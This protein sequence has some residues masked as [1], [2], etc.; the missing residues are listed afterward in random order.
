MSLVK[1]ELLSP[2]GSYEGFLAAIGA[3]ADAVYCG[4]SLFGARAYAKNF[5]KEELLKAIRIAHIH[6]R[7]LYLTVNT[8]FKNAELE[9]DLYEYLAPF[10]QEGLDAVLVQ[11]MGALSFIREKFPGLPIHASTQ[12]TVTGPL[13]G[14]F[15]KEQGVSRIVAARELSL[16]ELAVLHEETSLEI[17]AFIHGAM[18][19]AYSGQCLMSSLIGGRSGNRGRCAQPC[20][21]PYT[22]CQG[23]DLFGETPVRESRRKEVSERTQAGNENR[24]GRFADRGRRREES[25]AEKGRKTPSGTT[26]EPFCAISMKDMSTL[27][28]LPDILS[29][30]VYSLKIEGRMKQPAYTAAVTR[31]YRKYLDI[32]LENGVSA[33]KNGV[34]ADKKKPYTVEAT[35][36]ELLLSAYSRGGST[37]GY[38]KTYHGPGMIDL[39]SGKK[40]TIESPEYA[41]PRKGVRM[42]AV[43]R[44]GEPAALTLAADTDSGTKSVRA[45]G[46]SVQRA[47]RQA[48]SRE[49]VKEQLS[50]MGNTE[51]AIEDFS[52][53]MDDDIFISMKELNELRREAADALA[54]ALY[55]EYLRCPEESASSRPEAGEASLPGEKAFSHQ[56]GEA[57][58]PDERAFFH[59][60][61]NTSFSD[62]PEY[63]PKLMASCE[64]E[65]TAAALM[66]NPDIGGLYLPM[67]LVQKF[68]ADGLS[69]GKEMYLILPRI[70]RGKAPDGYRALCRR[71]LDKG[72]TGFL[73][74]DLEGYCLMREEGLA[75]VTVLDH[76]LYTWNNRAEAFFGGAGCLRLT[77]PLELNER[78]IS[79]RDN[80]GGEMLVYGRLPL[81][82]SAQCVQKNYFGCLSKARTPET[83]GMSFWPRTLGQKKKE[84]SSPLAIQDRTQAIFPVQAVCHPWQCC[85]E[86]P[87]GKDAPGNGTQSPARLRETDNTASLPSCY[88]IIYNSIP[89]GLLPEAGRVKKLGFSVLRLSFT[90]EDENEAGRIASA[91]ADA[92]LRDKEVSLS[93]PLTKGHFKRGAE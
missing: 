45:E 28:I 29:A 4:G 63:M 67:P 20:R 64:D 23:E 47:E 58:F 51:F 73:A 75:P 91:F 35:D 59:Q 14:R 44:V 41:Y 54:Q 90:T 2:A 56:K 38:Y 32:L 61:E 79:A 37:P 1:A 21:L 31:I 43:L 15:L 50:K 49:R 7:K 34:S 66:R 24:Q 36:R 30:G 57:S 92:Y 40:T 81:M 25:R 68:L 48:V 55:K 39:S 74:R 72:L 86:E 76:S 69:C 52:L 33:D 87:K 8:L 12:M 85:P 10:Y 13:G 88:N 71:L 62:K 26:K 78:E 65:A 17:E 3:G 27:D 70:I 83:D 5:E 19:Y 53:S 82:I 60:K 6:G 93:L 22:P 46:G 77:C 18:C 42:E 11:D 89:F 80:R 9:S 84:M 16:S